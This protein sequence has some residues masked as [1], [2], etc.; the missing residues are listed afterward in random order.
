MLDSDKFLVV[1]VHKDSTE[2]GASSSSAMVG[3]VTGQTIYVK[4]DDT[5][6]LE[7][8]FGE[9]NIFSVYLLQTM[10]DNEVRAGQLL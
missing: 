5:V 3:C 2:H 4:A 1:H 10:P 6:D 7:D 8:N 9:R